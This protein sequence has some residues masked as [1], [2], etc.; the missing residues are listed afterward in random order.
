MKN[1]ANL[2]QWL[3]LADIDYF[4]CFVKAWIP[5]NAWYRHEYEAIKQEREIIDEVKKDGNRIRARFIANIDS[6]DPDAEEMRNHIAALHRRL[7]QD[8]LTPRKKHRITFEKVLIG[9]NPET[10]A[11]HKHGHWFYRVERL[12]NKQVLCTVISN[13]GRIDSQFTQTNGWNIEEF[14]LHPDFLK[15]NNED[16][17]FLHQSYAAANPSI[18]K[19]VLADPSHGQS[20]LMDGYHFTNDKNAVFSALIEILY[21]MRNLLF[22]GE[23]VPDPQ[24]NRTYEPAYHILRRLL[25]YVVTDG[26]A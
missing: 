17:A 20:L 18:F 3:D 6:G 15:L 8:P 9:P 10:K 2:K 24:T 4:T 16:R 14:E 26:L 13:R 25:E 23:V 21:A 11:E 22:H 1:V 5:L 7:S 12:P 19:S